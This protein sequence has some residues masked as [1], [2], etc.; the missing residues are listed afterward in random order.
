M[1]RTL[2]PQSDPAADALVKRFPRVAE[3]LGSAKRTMVDENPPA[4]AIAKGLEAIG[5]VQNVLDPTGLAF[6][7]SPGMVVYHMTAPRAA[8]AIKT[9]GT[10]IPKEDGLF[11]S[12][13]KF[14]PA[15][16]GYGTA[17]VKLDIPEARLILDDEFP[18]GE[19]HYRLPVESGKPAD[20]S[21][22]LLDRN[23][24][25]ERNWDHP[26]M[27]PKPPPPDPMYRTDTGDVVQVSLGKPG[28]TGDWGNPSYIDKNGKRQWISRTRL[29]TWTKVGE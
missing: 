28:Q 22:W 13:K 21:Q 25:I 8:N 3:W 4:E 27:K 15:S 23:A 1:P 12:N 29:A 10:M 11:F 18:T 5:K 24:P 14:G 17:A 26:S 2:K 7:P 6:S 9:S 19:K 20:V 16:E